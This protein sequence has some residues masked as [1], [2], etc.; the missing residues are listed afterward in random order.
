MSHRP[1]AA[2]G[3]ATIALALSTVL[4]GTADA[5]PSHSTGYPRFTYEGVYPDR[6]PCSGG[7]RLVHSTSANVNGRTISLKYYY[8]GGCGSF[9]RIDNAPQGCYAWLDR[10][11]YVP[12]GTPTSW[13]WVRESVDPGINYAYT[14]IGNNLNGRVSRAA[15]VC[16]TTVYARTAWY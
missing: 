5:A 3:L 16:G 15:L 9:A 1:K 7:F 11:P 13:D 12:S 4:S 14:Q 10:T 6:T 8:S 2:I